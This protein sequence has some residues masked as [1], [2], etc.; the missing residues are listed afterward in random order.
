[1]ETP[2]PVLFLLG[3]SHHTAALAVR[4]KL[5]LDETRAA[6]LATRLQAIPDLREFTL[7]NTCNRVEVYGVAPA[8]SVERATARARAPARYG[9][10][11]RARPRSQVRNCRRRSMHCRS[12][13]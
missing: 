1:M 7:L 9:W 11:A 6:T 12:Q 10:T 3:A 4:E 5:A 8:A 13:R 2:P